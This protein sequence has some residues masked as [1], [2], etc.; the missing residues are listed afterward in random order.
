[1]KNKRAKFRGKTSR[2][3]NRAQVWQEKEETQETLDRFG[4]KS[5]I[6]WPELSIPRPMEKSKNG[7]IPTRKIDLK[8][9]RRVYKCQ[10]FG[11][12]QE[13]LYIDSNK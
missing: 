7:I 6:S 11:T 9:N 4:Q 13:F 5:A 8:G 10:T 3:S 1:M 12:L 2:K